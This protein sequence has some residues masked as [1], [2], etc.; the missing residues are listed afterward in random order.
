MSSVI[1]ER[2]HSGRQP[3]SSRAQVSSSESGQLRAIS[4]LT[5]SML[6]SIVNEGMRLRI[7]AAMMSGVKL[8]E[9]MLKLLRWRS[10]AGSASISSTQA[11]STSGM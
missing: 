1:R 8:I 2:S 5:G 3:H 11:R 9:A 7:S 10:R 6:K 4:S